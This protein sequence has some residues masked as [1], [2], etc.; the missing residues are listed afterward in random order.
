MEFR[1]ATPADLPRIRHLWQLCFGDEPAY[2]DRFLSAFFAPGRVLTLV[3]DGDIQSM[4]FLLPATLRTAQRDLDTVYLYAMCTSP[5][6]QGRGLGLRFL[7]GLA[8]YGRAL[9]LECL[10][11]MPADEGLF[12]FYGKG[13]YETAFFC[14]H[15][16]WDAPQN[17][18]PAGEVVPVD[19]PDYQ[20]LRRAA[21]RGL[22]GLDYT[23]DYVAYQA[24]DV[25][26]GGG[27]CYRL[28]LPGGVCGCAVVERRGE[29]ARCVELLIDPAREGEALALLGKNLH[30]SRLTARAPVYAGQT[31]APFGMVQWLGETRYDLGMPF[32]GLALD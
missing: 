29:T 11:L 17:T 25:I 18:A 4:I 8:D 10:T 22:S 19:A 6:H 5:D 23:A 7:E 15:L 3:E 16:Q 31:G 13:G 14:R 20:V 9:G 1:T 12:R 32:M 27:G 30:V 21:L 28:T 26:D 24:R 2:I